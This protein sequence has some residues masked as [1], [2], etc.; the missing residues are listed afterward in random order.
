MTPAQS[1][2]FRKLRFDVDHRIVPAAVLHYHRLDLVGGIDD[3]Q[4]IEGHIHR[5]LLVRLVDVDIG[6]GVNH[7]RNT[8]LGVNHHEA[9]SEHRLVVVV[10]IVD[11]EAVV[12]THLQTT[13]LVGDGQSVVGVKHVRV[14]RFL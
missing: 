9:D 10:V 7:H 2:A 1:V 4:T 14:E 12:A 5:H 8:H 11:G 13:V 3:A 6:I